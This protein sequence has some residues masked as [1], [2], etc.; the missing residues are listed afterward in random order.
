MQCMLYSK[1]LHAVAA[2]RQACHRAT[3]AVAVGHQ[4][5]A[6]HQG[7]ASYLAQRCLGS[8][9]HLLVH[10]PLCSVT[11]NNIKIGRCF[12][13]AI[14]RESQLCSARLQA[15]IRYEAIH[16]RNYRHRVVMLLLMQQHKSLCHK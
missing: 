11:S 7:R 9:Y 15:L 8:D 10:T 6:V 16:V 5:C 4:M 12:H 3:L 1:Y 2:P 14:E 13:A